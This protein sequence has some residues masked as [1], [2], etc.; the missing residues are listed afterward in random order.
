M[1]RTLDDLDVS[2]KR[3]FLRADLNVPMRDGAVT[4]TNRIDRLARHAPRANEIPTC[5]WAR[6]QG[7]Y[8][9]LSGGAT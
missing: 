1:A 2:G 3:V 8:R 4:D 6:S 5:R 7:R 9:R